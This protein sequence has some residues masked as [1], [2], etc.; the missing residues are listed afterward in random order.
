MGSAVY[1]GGA[2]LRWHRRGGGRAPLPCRAVRL[3]KSAELAGLAALVYL[4]FLLSSPGQVSADSKQALY[5]DPGGLLDRA[6]QLW[7]PSTGAGGVPHQQLGYLVPTGP[8]F[9]VFD[10]VGVPDWVAQRLWWGTLSLVAVLGARW[11]LEL[12]GTGRAG[13]LAGA[14]VY[15]CTPY[16]LAFT[17]RISVLLLPWAAL[18]WLVGLTARA[19]RTGSWRPPALLALALFLVGGVNASSLLLV[20]LG[21]ALWLV[22]EAGRGR[23]EARRVLAASARIGGLAVG[24]SLWWLVGVRLQGAY[25]LPVLQLT[26]NLRTVAERSSPDD[27]LRGLGNWFFYGRDRTGY[28][29]DQAAAYGEHALV[30]ALTFA[31]PMVALAVATCVRWA[32]AA[33]FMTLVAVGTIVA[34]GAWPFDDPSPYGRLWRTFADESSLGL[35]F[36]NSPRA[37]PLVVLGLAGLLAAAVGALDRRGLRLGGAALVGLLAIAGLLPVW[38]QGYTTDGMLRPEHLPGHW[39]E[40]AAD[41]D[42]GDSGTR[43]LELPGSSFAAYS[44]GTTVDPVTPLLIERPYLAR[45]V[46]PDGTPPTANLLAALDRRIQLGTFEPESLAPL[47]RLLGVGTISVRA[48]LERA[49][50]FDT[51][52]VEDLWGLLASP[53]APGLEPPRR[54]GPPGGAGEDPDLPSVGLFEV[55]DP[56][57]IVRIRATEQPIVLAGDGDGVVDAAAAG[58]VDGRSLLLQSAAIDDVTLDDALAAGA[59]LILT[60][61]H[62]KRAETW[63]YSIRDTRGPT[64]RM[65]ERQPDPTGYDFRL[66]PFAGAGDDTRTVAEHLGGTVEAT[67]A[68]GAERPEDR[69]VHAVDGDPASAWRV[70]GD[71]RGATLRVVPALAVDADEIVLL[72]A[73]TASGKAIQT[74]AVRVPGHAPITVDLGAASLE[75]PGQRVP[76]PSGSV[77]QVEVEIIEVALPAG[78]ADSSRVGLAEVGIG[79]LV[80]EETLRLPQDLL[81]R[82]GRDLDGHALDLVLTRLHWGPDD[83]ARGDEEPRLDRTVELPVGR[84]FSVAGDVSGPPEQLVPDPRCRD[85]LLVVDGAAVPVRLSTEADGGGS[86]Q[87]CAP[88]ELAPGP[89]RIQGGSAAGVTVDRLVLSSDGQGAPAAVAPRGGGRADGALVVGRDDPGAVDLTVASDG[90]PVWVVL[91]QSSSDGW[92]IDVAGGRAG[93]RQLVDGYANGWLVT[94]D[95]DGEMALTLRWTPQRA[96]PMGLIVSALA[97]V[98]VLAIMVATR[99]EPVGGDLR[100]SPRLVSPISTGEGRARWPWRRAALV[101]TTALA[102]ASPVVAFVAVLAV[103]LVGRWPQWRVAATVGAPVA[104]ALS[105][106]EQ[107]P[108]LAWL[109][110]ALAVAALPRPTHDQAPAA[111]TSTLSSGTDPA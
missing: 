93:P 66:E 30:V 59:D 36:R 71:A 39:D 2:A 7:D 57:P 44:W 8:W 88:V 18:P 60:D 90:D 28:S 38:Q 61:S 79:S 107:R 23:V 82:V 26:E 109:A 98:A 37:V 35:A 64:E 70:G 54:Y 104:L 76:I 68:G 110:V 48:D 27:V 95:G 41:L 10:Q 103:F 15:G 4:P 5:L 84:T 99:R 11:L 6:T 14:L 111:R 51:P 77:E 24:V 53:E 49:G 34:V 108:T 47:A 45:E 75:A 83:A 33:Y 102:V 81:E 96:V 106:I 46:L 92:G 21:P 9:W 87:S 105:R 101:G 43:V 19:S 65:G 94:P 31:V 32:H 12:L 85:D 62:R 17:A 20:A 3:R 78:P 42:Q 50:R 97:L 58:L 63:F 52:A 69:A 80:V 16:Q 1:E 56:N 55:E 73:A 74:V 40:A 100:R 22:L 29:V 89:H 25:G 91:G 86:L 67:A 13:A 72:Q